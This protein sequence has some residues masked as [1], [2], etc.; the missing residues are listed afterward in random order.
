MLLLIRLQAA[1]KLDSCKT[2]VH[3]TRLPF[4]SRRNLLSSGSTLGCSIQSV[5]CMDECA[6]ALSRL[7][8]NFTREFFYNSVYPFV[9]STPT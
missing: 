6:G 8:R 2:D 3:K 5:L 1:C 9:P 4:L 7:D